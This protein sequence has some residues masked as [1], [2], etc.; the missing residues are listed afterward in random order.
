MTGVQNGT[1][2]FTRSKHTQT[3]LQPL[4]NCSLPGE[5]PDKIDEGKDAGDEDQNR[6]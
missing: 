2:V 5:I 4:L 3:V 6:R 1:F